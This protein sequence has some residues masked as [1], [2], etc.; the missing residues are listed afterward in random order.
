MTYETI[1]VIAVTLYIREHLKMEFGDLDDYE[2][3]IEPIIDLYMSEEKK[4]YHY[5]NEF[6]YSEQEEIMAIINKKR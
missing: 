5:I 6:L 2:R 3:V 4:D 1:H